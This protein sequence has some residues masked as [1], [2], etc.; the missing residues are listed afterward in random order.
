M[1]QDVDRV[2]RANFGTGLLSNLGDVDGRKT[3]LVEQWLTGF[4]EQ[5]EDPALKQTLAERW[6]VIRGKRLSLDKPTIR[7]PGNRMG[8]I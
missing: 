2:S 3:R 5:T 8:G 1:I 7:P 4:I 6:Q